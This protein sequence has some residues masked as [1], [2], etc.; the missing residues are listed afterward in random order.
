MR[1]DGTPYSNHDLV[2]SATYELLIP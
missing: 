2:Y 1:T